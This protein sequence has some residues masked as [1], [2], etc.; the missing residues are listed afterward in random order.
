M[1]SRLEL[2]KARSDLVALYRHL[3]DNG[4]YQL[5]VYLETIIDRIDTGMI[6]HEEEIA[7]ERD[8][9]FRGA[10]FEGDL[11]GWLPDDFS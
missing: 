11:I 3:W 5:A 2:K 7:Q 10:A 1:S 8:A 9:A 4:E 6:L